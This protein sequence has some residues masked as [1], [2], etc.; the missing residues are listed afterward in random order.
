[1]DLLHGIY[2]TLYYIL[3]LPVGVFFTSA[4]SLEAHEGKKETILSTTEYLKLSKTYKYIMSAHP[5]HAGR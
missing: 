2:Y 4:F 3:Y 5:I 1:M